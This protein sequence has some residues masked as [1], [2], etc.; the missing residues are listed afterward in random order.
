MAA[1]YAERPGLLRIG[2]QASVLGA[3]I[4]LGKIRRA[5]RCVLA[6]QTG[7]IAIDDH[8]LGE[9]GQQP[10]A[11]KPAGQPV[12]TPPASEAATDQVPSA[13]EA[14]ERSRRRG[15]HG[16][17]LARRQSGRGRFPQDGRSRPDRGGPRRRGAARK[18]HA[19]AADPPRSGAAARL[20]ARSAT[21]HPQQY[22][23]WRRADQPGQ[24][25]AQGKAAAARH[26]ARCL[27]L[28]EHVHRR[29]PALHPRRAR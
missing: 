5:V 1:G 24:A 26:A 20:P 22:Q 2:V 14:P 10:V 8:G 13:D 9:G 12:R 29:V 19:H 15:P 23:P 18:N 16:R 6:R 3:Q 21:N 28:D 7:A 11:E 4:R 17:R 25:A 27:R